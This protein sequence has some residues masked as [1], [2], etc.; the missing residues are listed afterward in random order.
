M[1]LGSSAVAD[2][3][4]EVALAA[5]WDKLDLS[6]HDADAIYKSMGAKLE[7]QPSCGRQSA[8]TEG[9][10]WTAYRGIGRWKAGLATTNIDARKK[11]L[12]AWGPGDVRD[13]GHEKSQFWLLRAGERHY[14]A[15]WNG[16]P[17]W[18]IEVSELT[19]LK[20]V[21]DIATSLVGKTHEEI[22]R[23]GDAG[24]GLGCETSEQRCRLDYGVNEVAS[25]TTQVEVAFDGA[26][27]AKHVDVRL[28]VPGI[29]ASGLPAR[30][31]AALG[32]S[33]ARTCSP[34]R[35]A[36]KLLTFKSTPKMTVSFLTKAP[37]EVVMCFGDCPTTCK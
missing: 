20:Q 31:D 26:P 33:T 24:P 1:A 25:L 9:I 27:A 35:N 30:I 29:P 15:H 5:P 34:K 11:M 3:V 4:T 6:S 37:R 7:T 8:L 32:K 12:D 28:M 16:N 22:L 2:P 21:A 17:Q 23:I 36:Y 19:S 14:I 18:N 13:D 10:C